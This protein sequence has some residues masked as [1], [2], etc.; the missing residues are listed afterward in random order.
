[1]RQQ[2][3]RVC[4]APVGGYTT[5]RWP[6]DMGDP[7]HP[8]GASAAGGDAV[9]AAAEAA[10][11]SDWRAQVGGLQAGVDAHMRRTLADALLLLE[12]VRWVCAGQLCWV[13][14]W[15]KFPAGM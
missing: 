10:A 13:K 4:Q 2:S 5:Q 3:A 15:I 8:A 9:N 7:P 6:D 12:P 1:M 14:P 11:G